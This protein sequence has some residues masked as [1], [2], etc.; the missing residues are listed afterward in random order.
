MVHPMADMGHSVNKSTSNTNKSNGDT[1]ILEKCNTALPIDNQGDNRVST[2]P[3][4]GHKQHHVQGDVV[5]SDFQVDSVNALADKYDL[6]LRFAYRHKD[7]LSMATDSNIFQAWKAQTVGGYGFIPLN[8]LV[9]P[10][11]V[12]INPSLGDP[13]ADHKYIKNKVVC[14]YLGP[15]L[16]IKSQLNPDVWDKYL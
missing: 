15:Q 4:S 8:D 3:Y 6:D 16:Q 1:K 5:I 10:E 11:V 9:L 7:C 14:N 2:N 12:N 13:I